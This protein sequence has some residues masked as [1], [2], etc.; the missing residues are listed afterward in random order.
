[1]SLQVL[2]PQFDSTNRCYT[3]TFNH[4]PTF[5]ENTSNPM[6]LNINNDD[7]LEFITEFLEQA[8]KH[9]SKVLE[10]D[11]FF[12]RMS[13]S[14][15]TEDVDLKSIMESGETFRATW[16]PARITFYT[17]RYDLQWNLCELEKVI[18]TTSIP[19]GFLD[20]TAVTVNVTLESVLPEL[21]EAGPIEFGGVPPAERVE[22]ENQRKRIRQARLRAALAKLQAERLAERYY[23]RYGNFDWGNSDSELSSGSDTPNQKNIGLC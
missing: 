3:F 14:Y 5:E 19:P 11:L 20:E 4:A 10:P 2:S 23:K 17:N 22:K 13:H 7:L 1:M 16:I 18:E 12:R 6:V 9:F 21:V 8:S 15:N